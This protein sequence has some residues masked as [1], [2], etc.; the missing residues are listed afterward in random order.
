MDNRFV[1]TIGRQFCSGGRSVGKLVAEKLGVEFY[2]K[3]LI[4][5]AAKKS[6]FTESIFEKADEVPSN[7]LLYSV[8]MSTYPMNTLHFHNNNLITND[9]LFG[10]QSKVIQ[11]LA[12]DKSCVI[13]G[14]CSD[15]IL[16]D[17][18]NLTRIFIRA[19]ID[20]REKRCTEI[21]ENVNEKDV[22]GLIN[23][24]DKKR[25]TYYGY[26]TGNVWDNMNNYD[27]VVNTAK[28]GIENAADLIIDYINASKK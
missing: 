18:P 19:D 5:L 8:V 3:E 6:G 13:V 2:D 26:Y 24:T 21:Y 27:L 22:A 28:V 14:R 11:D 1:I 4:A 16:K 15:Y 17:V 23:K 10:I 9:R 20:F 25:A 7:S 12:K